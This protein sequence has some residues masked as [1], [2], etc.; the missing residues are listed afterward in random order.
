MISQ[1]QDDKTEPASQA[2][3][4]DFVSGTYGGTDQLCI[5]DNLQS[6]LGV[7]T[8]SEARRAGIGVASDSS[9]VLAPFRSDIVVVREE[10]A[11][12]TGLE[13]LWAD[14]LQRCRADGTTRLHL[15]KG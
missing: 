11:A 4:W 9:T 8:M 6:L 15:R 1:H 7:D 3:G 13:M 5:A 14:N 2:I 10:D 12:P